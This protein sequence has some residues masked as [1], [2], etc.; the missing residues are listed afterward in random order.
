MECEALQFSRN[1][2]SFRPVG[3]GRRKPWDFGK[4]ADHSPEARE[5]YFKRYTT[6]VSVSAGSVNQ[7]RACD[8]VSSATWLTSR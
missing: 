3:D 2:R 6:V 8:R 5:P 1:K 7:K 4:A